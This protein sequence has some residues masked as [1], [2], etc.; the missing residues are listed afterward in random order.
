MTKNL[1]DTKKIAIL[2]FLAFAFS[3]AA[4]LYWISY[5][6][7]IESF[8]FN[9]QIMINTNDGYFY[10]EGARD[11]IKGSHEA[12]DRSAVTEPVAIATAALYKILP[13]SLET[14]TLYMPAFFGSLVV[15]PVILI[16]RFFGQPMMGFFAAMFGAITYSYYNR[17]M[18]GYYDSD[19]FA[20]IMPP[21]VAAFLIGYFKEK[22]VLWQ[23]LFLAS[24][25]LSKILYPQ[26]YSWMAA[27]IAF[28]FIYALIFD[29]RE[30]SLYLTV[31]LSLLAISDLHIAAKT[32]LLAAGVYFGPQITQKTSLLLLAVAAAGAVFAFFGG[33]DPILSSLK[34][35][36]FKDSLTVESTLKYY[37]VVQT[38]REAGK[39]DPNLFASRISGSLP[40]FLA[41]IVGYLFFIKKERL[42]A[43]TLPIFGL[44]LFAYFGGLRFT[45]YAVPFAS[46]GL[47]FIVFYAL[48]KF[49]EPQKI[50][51][52]SIAFLLLSIPNFFH[53]YNYKVP[54]VFSSGLASQLT[55]LQKSAKRE[56]YVFAW[57]DYGYPIRYY[58]DVKNHSDGGKHDG[59]TNFIESFILSNTNQRAAANMMRESVE[60]YEELIKKGAEYKTGTL[61]YILSKRKIEPQNYNSYLES[62]K[63]EGFE[64][65]PKT[66]DVYLFLPLD[67]LDIF[68]TVR[69]FSDINLSTG[70]ST[71]DPYFGVFED[72]EESENSI[73]FGVAVF[74]KKT[75]TIRVG[76]NTLPVKSISVTYYD[77]NGSFFSKTE[78]LSDTADFHLIAMP[79]QHTY[80]LADDE[81]FNSVFIQLFVLQNYDTTLFEPVSM[82]PEAK[83][84]RLKI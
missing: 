63:S 20:L 31:A 1:L 22:R 40:V 83:I 52:A 19:M 50:A 11:L 15:I 5:A 79:S 48:K 49:A 37:D 24:L 14:L 82:T 21:F 41:A 13:F 69:L 61:E 76:Q 42:F 36:L 81:M 8:Y 56:D 25:A 75:K 65:L 54:T 46:L 39:M 45:V 32:I 29:R 3:F 74:D 57:W 35:Y 6:S 55:E 16:G 30:L 47:F 64:P 12:G 80:I 26:S 23:T 58:A 38:V 53:I 17:T 71:K 51:I 2:M 7:G 72:F 78:K 44:G 68:P 43:L 62:L 4:R 60:G 67:M 84:F 28:A 10:A 77:K 27:T 33:L 70:E 18:A 34:A 66:R 73:N 9:N 59:A